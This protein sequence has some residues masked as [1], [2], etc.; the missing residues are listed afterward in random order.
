MFGARSSSG[1]DHNISRKECVTLVDAWGTCRSCD[2]CLGSGGVGRRG[3]I[4]SPVPVGKF[5]LYWII[6]MSL[7][8]RF[9]HTCDDALEDYIA[10]TPIFC[11]Y[12][13]ENLTLRATR[14]RWGSRARPPSKLGVELKADTLTFEYERH[15]VCL[16]VKTSNDEPSHVSLYARNLRGVALSSCRS[17]L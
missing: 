7:E 17:S 1:T 12:L 9:R 8:P 11:L 16:S 3:A 13:V 14:A 6:S 4:T 5:R 10:M 2:R 15:R